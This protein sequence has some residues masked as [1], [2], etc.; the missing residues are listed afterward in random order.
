MNLV[1]WFRKNN[2]KVMAVVVI[3]LM[4]GFVGGSAL[5]QLLRSSGGMNKAVAY[6]GLKKHKITPSDRAVARQELEILQALGAGQILQYQDL[7]GV[8][9]GELL[10]SE[11]SGS[12]ELIIS[13]RIAISSVTSNSR[14][15]TTE[16][17]RPT[18]TGS[19][20]VTRPTTPASTCAPRTSAR[21]SAR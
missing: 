18:S 20:C 7:R 19:S 6:Y 15:C 9:L 3:V 13:S 2:T 5:T 17:C 21:C 8:L 10:F 1:K 4:V 14:R 12:A 16:R 11:S